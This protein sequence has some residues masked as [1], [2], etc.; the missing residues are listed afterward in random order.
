MNK[1]GKIYFD[2]AASTPVAP[3]VLAAM[4]PYF[5]KKFGNAGSL[6]FFGQ[7]AQAAVDKSRETI[8]KIIGAGFREVIFT[9]SA[10]EANNLVLRGVAR[11][12]RGIMSLA[13]QNASGYNRETNLDLPP[14]LI[15]SAIEHE[16]ILETA[17]DL[18]QEGVEVLYLPVDREG[19]VIVE[20]LKEMLND[21]TILVSVMYAN[22]EI[23]TIQNISKI[24]EII[25]SFRNE[26]SKSKIQNLNLGTVYP[27]IHTDAV[28][29]FQYLDCNVNNLGVDF[30][31]LSAHKI[32][33]PKGVGALYARNSNQKA[34]NS[35]QIQNHK[36]VSNLEFQI[37]DLRLVTPI[38]TG[39]GQE[40]GFRSGT[41]N[42]PAIVGFAK[43]AELVFH[44]RESERRRIGKLRDYF[45]S[46][47]KKIY[48][49][50]EVNGCADAPTGAR[51]FS[52][53]LP[54][55]IN[56]Y[57]PDHLA[58]DLLI[59]LDLEGIAASAGSACSARSSK[60]SHVLRAL[61]LPV[62][63]ILRSLRFSLGRPSK[64]E[65][66]KMALKVLENILSV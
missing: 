29:A 62:A 8:A 36:N 47:L 32:Y 57:F 44:S 60:P 22:N 28:Q 15:V 54:N 65:E 66:I 37:S 23:G 2:Y 19:Y 4:E 31:T 11:A 35:E 18:E 46:K 20:K 43:A 25:R 33:G 63:R 41:E 9:G 16:S 1:T 39:G 30:M 49:K 55:I 12:A 5:S 26:N 3:A 58:E 6:H 48:P 21:Q 24:S 52:E 42:V 64:L 34:Q 51:G 50:V 10:T 27:L 13:R 7:E 40:Y 17:K 61:G 59:K 53:Q 56:L 38:V 14:R 45:L